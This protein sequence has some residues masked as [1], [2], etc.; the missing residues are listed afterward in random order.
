MKTG[1]RRHA[2]DTLLDSS[3]VVLMTEVRSWRAQRSPNM[4]A[5]LAGSAQHWSAL[6][7]LCHERPLCLARPACVLHGHGVVDAAA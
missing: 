4:T 3:H 1:S 2:L 6:L 5:A 7:M